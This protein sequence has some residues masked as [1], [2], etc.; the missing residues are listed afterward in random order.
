MS[1][2]T[3][4]SC[5]T[6]LPSSQT[7]S[8]LSSQDP[9]AH[10][11]FPHTGGGSACLPSSLSEGEVLILG[12]ESTGRYTPSPALPSLP[13]GLAA[14]P[15]ILKGPAQACSGT[16]TGRWVCPRAHPACFRALTL[17]F[18]AGC[19]RVKKRRRPQPTCHPIQEIK[20]RDALPLTYIPS[21]FH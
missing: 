2:A 8:S 3:F 10:E 4:F 12:W 9:F 13:Q 6:N 17:H 21:S 18:T 11:N 15:I 16:A 5:E 14:S 19:V 20:P 7:G 1:F